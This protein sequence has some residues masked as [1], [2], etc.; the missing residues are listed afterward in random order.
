MD[1][2]LLGMRRKR[3]TGFIRRRETKQAPAKKVTKPKFS[4]IYNV[5]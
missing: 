1:G 4:T 5:L 3:L 2:Y